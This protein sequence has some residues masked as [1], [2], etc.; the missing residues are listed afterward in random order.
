MLLKELPVDAD[1][2]SPEN[3][4]VFGAGP[5]VGTNVVASCRMNIGCK[6]V[7]TGGVGAADVG[8]Y[9]APELKF[10][11]Y[12]NIVITDK[13]E[14]PVFLYIK[15]DSIQFFEQIRFQEPKNSDEKIPEM[16]YSFYKYIIA[17]NHFKN[18]LSIIENVFEGEKSKIDEIE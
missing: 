4:L 17:I 6:N 3:I 13:A 11:G 12:D 8:G 2:L 14:R 18:T 16:V 15:D 10:A 9:F 1:P 5:L 7:L